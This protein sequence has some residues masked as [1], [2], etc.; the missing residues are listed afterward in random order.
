MCMTGQIVSDTSKNAKYDVFQLL[1]GD[2]SVMAS[3]GIWDNLFDEDICR[4]LEQSVLFGA[5][6]DNITQRDLEVVSKEI[7]LQATKKAADEKSI[8][9]WSKSVVKHYKQRYAGG[10]PDDM[11]VVVSYFTK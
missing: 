9:P 4:I 3:D 10:K 2:V 1:S 7:V 11:T 6:N 5:N 8:T